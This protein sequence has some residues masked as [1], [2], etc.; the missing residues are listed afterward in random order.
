MQVWSSSSLMST[1]RHSQL[2][3]LL[4]LSLRPTS[5]ESCRGGCWEF[6]SLSPDTLDV[7]IASLE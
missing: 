7:N 6:A 4:A 5:T 2:V 1:I 3:R